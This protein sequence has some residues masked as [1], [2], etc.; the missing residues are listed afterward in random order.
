[1]TPTLDDILSVVAGA[2]N[3]QVSDIKQKSRK[4]EFVI[5]RAA[6]CMIAHKKFGVSSTIVGNHVGLEHSSVL[7]ACNKYYEYRD[8]WKIIPKEVDEMFC[9]TPA[10]RTE[11]KKNKRYT[12]M[13][14]EERYIHILLERGH[15]T[16]T[17]FHELSSILRNN[18]TPWWKIVEQQIGKS[19]Q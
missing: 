13:T 1:M 16:K 3:L 6:F 4:R 11:K 14:P 7:S 15:V 9:P 10:Q 8:F 5:A 2:F 12:T 17:K 19:K 18:P